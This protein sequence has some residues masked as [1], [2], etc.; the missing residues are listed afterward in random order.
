[1]KKLL[2]V[3]L[4][5]GVVLHANA[6]DPHF[7]Q[8]HATPLLVNPAL[9]GVQERPQLLLNYR[10]QW[11]S[12][13]P[14]FRTIQASYDQTLSKQRVNKGRLAA[15]ISVLSDR[16][17]DLDLGQIQ[18]IAS[19]A[20]HVPMGQYSRLGAALNIGAGQRSISSAGFRWGSQYDGLNFDPSLAGGT[21]PTDDRFIFADVGAGMVYSY[22]KGERYLTSND[23]RSFTVGL[24]VHHVNKPIF[25]FYNADERLPMRFVLHGEG[26]LGIA[27]TN[28][29]FVPGILFQRQGVMS[30]LVLGSRIRYLLEGESNYTG[31]LKGKAISLGGF[32]RTGDAAIIS[33]QIELGSYDFGFSYDLNVSDLSDASRGR[34]GSE[35]YFR[36]LLPGSAAKGG[37]RRY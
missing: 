35:I 5:C 33:I 28:L 22:S 14:S 6:Q 11:G 26:L 17:G 15:G 2:K 23:Q 10:S 34:G 19:V 1:M 37:A 18:G 16:A 7:S 31:F 27:N 12:L 13:G 8:F 32:Y 3:L 29:S 30:E 4:L 9:T 25:S 21:P 20:Y 24:A 36:Y